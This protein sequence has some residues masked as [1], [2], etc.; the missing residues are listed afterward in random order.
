MAPERINIPTTP[1][2][3]VHYKYPYRSLSEHE[4]E[5]MVDG[6]TQPRQHG[7]KR[8]L[9]RIEHNRTATRV[10]WFFVGLTCGAIIAAIVIIPIYQS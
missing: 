7:P 3:T 9:S 8:L 4:H 2:T 5:H 1:T 6:F 10:F